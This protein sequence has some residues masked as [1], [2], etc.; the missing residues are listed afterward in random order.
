M[1]IRIRLWYSVRNEIMEVME[2]FR[3]DSSEKSKDSIFKEIWNWSSWGLRMGRFW[4]RLGF[5]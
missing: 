3:A 5:G 4:W 2:D 1:W